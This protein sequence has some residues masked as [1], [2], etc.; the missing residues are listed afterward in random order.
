MDT[1]SSAL[2]IPGRRL[3]HGQLPAGA[4]NDFK[5]G[6]GLQEL[7]AVTESIPMPD[8]S[9]NLNLTGGHSELQSHYLAYGNLH[10]Q[11]GRNAGL[12]DVDRMPANHL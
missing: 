2:Y 3:G 1:N 6:N 11:H 12:A 9:V 5:L 10:A 7:K 4:L 8:E